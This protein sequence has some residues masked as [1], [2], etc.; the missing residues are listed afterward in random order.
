[1]P[2]PLVSARLSGIATGLSWWCYFLALQLGEAS[3]MAPADKLGTVFVIILAAVFPKEN[4]L[5][6]PWSAAC[7]W[8]PVR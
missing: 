1:M 3:R 4:S 2:S 5:S 7:W 6:N 8:R